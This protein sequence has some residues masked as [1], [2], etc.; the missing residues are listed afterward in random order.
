MSK[1]ILIKC[2][3]EVI[4]AIQSFIVL[5]ELFDDQYPMISAGR[6][7]F[8]RSKLNMA[9][10][11]NTISLNNQEKSLQIVVEDGDDTV[12][13]NGVLVYNVGHIYTSKDYY[14]LDNIVFVIKGFD[15]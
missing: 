3:Y 9:F 8:D 1:Q 6:V 14:I 11:Y 10:K 12:V 13:L 5:P 7:R 4:G 15:I 2:E